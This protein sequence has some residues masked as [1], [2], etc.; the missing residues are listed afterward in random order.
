[1]LLSGQDLPIKSHSE[2]ISFLSEDIHR[3][4]LHIASDYKN[5]NWRI[6]RYSPW[7]ESKSIRN[8]PLNKIN[9]TSI[10][11]QNLLNIKKPFFNNINIYMGSS[12]F[13][14]TNDAVEYILNNID[15]KL[16]EGF[17][18]T[19]CSDEHFIQTLLM[20]SPFKDN[21]V[22]ENI[23]YIDWSEGNP[24]PKVLTM[25]DYSK[26]KGSNKLFA[27]KFDID[28]DSDIINKITKL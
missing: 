1:T 12:W 25:D 17:K 21:V 19:T 7:S 22:G 3:E 26:L 20:N 18:S 11:L 4:F 15:D 28:I 16:I 27:R 10:K 5:Y 14:I 6:L 8:F 9:S 23:V 2:I 13:T 24:N